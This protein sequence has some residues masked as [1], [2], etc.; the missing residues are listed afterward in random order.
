MADQEINRVVFYSWQSDLPNATNRSFIQLALEKAAKSIASDKTVDDVPIIDRDTQ[1][2][3]GSPHIAKTI[4]QK[5]DVAD[6]FVAD[7]SIVGGSIERPA[8]NPNVLIEL[9]YALCSLKEGHQI[10]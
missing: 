6:V 3:P 2:V 8:P 10:T 4:F 5:I 9:G 7:V 1:G